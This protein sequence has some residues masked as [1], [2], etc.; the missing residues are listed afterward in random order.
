VSQYQKKTFTHSLP[1]S[2]GGPKHR[3]F[4]IHHIDATVQDEMK[5]FLLKCSQ[6]LW[7]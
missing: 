3:T 5:W 6:S 1:I 4:S 2:V 7:E